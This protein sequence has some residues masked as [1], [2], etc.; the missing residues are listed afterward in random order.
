[1]DADAN[2]LFHAKLIFKNQGLQIRFLKIKVYR[3]GFLKSRSTDQVFKNQGLQIRFLKSRS[4]DQDFK[5]QGL[6][7]RFLKI[8]VYRSGF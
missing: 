6:Q 2:P 7:I 1:M 4:T 5:N 8:K 3:S